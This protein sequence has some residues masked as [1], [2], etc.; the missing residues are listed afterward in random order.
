MSLDSRVY[1][2][3]A[4]TIMNRVSVLMRDLEEALISD[5]PRFDAGFLAL[6]SIQEARYNEL[7]EQKKIHQ[8]WC[9]GDACPRIC[10]ELL[11]D[12]ET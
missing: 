2:L 12:Q 11:H 3:L 4:E 9:V 1:S 8:I 10:T 5:S 6:Y 7:N